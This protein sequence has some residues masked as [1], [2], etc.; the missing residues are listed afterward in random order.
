[1]QETCNSFIG[2]DQNDN[3]SFHLVKKW[4]FKTSFCL[5]V[6]LKDIVSMT[7]PRLV[8]MMLTFE[9]EPKYPNLFALSV[10]NLF[11]FIV[12]WAKYYKNCWN[13]IIRSRIK[14]T[15]NTAKIFISLFIHLNAA[16]WKLDIR[17][18]KESY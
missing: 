4:R 8:F 12:V 3:K 6:Y 11:K 1:M 16:K 15:V 17:R 7:W 10:I 9:F 5:F 18:K 2:I 14:E 13:Y